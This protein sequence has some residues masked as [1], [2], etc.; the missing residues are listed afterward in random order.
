MLKSSFKLRGCN[1][2]IRPQKMWAGH[3]YFN[4]KLSHKKSPPNFV[5]Y[6]IRFCCKMTYYWDFNFQFSILRS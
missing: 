6:S 4:S 2:E 3:A 1:Y 5:G